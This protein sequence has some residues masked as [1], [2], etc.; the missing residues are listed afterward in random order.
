VGQGLG[1]IKGAVDF[2][3][4]GVYFMTVKVRFKLEYCVIAVNK[5]EEGEA[6]NAVRV[7]L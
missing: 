2:S 6:S 5:A 1:I 7:V 3:A 4:D